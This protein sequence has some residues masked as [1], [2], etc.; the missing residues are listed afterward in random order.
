MDAMMF[1]SEDPFA[2]PSQPSM[3]PASQQHPGSQTS[4]SSGGG[5]PQ[6]TMQ[7]YI[8]NMYDGIEGQLLEPIP[9]YL[10]Q[11]QQ[12]QRQAQQHGL[13]ATA[14]MYGTPNMMAM[15]PDHAS[16]AQQQQQRHHQQMA[17]HQQQQHQQQQQQQQQQ[18]GGGMMDEMLTD[19]TF[20]GEWDEMLG[21]TG[22]R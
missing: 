6:D 2:Y 16:H 9:S 17:Q 8:P 10:L 15:Q 13:N 20:R 1:P 21:N 7:F 11:Q 12:G 14:Q 3:D 5:Q 19:P 22:Y 4:Q 18:Q